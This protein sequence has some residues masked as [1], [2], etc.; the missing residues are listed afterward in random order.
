MKPLKIIDPLAQAVIALYFFIPFFSQGAFQGEYLEGALRG[1]YLTGLF[2]IGGWQVL[3]F[4]VHLIF[5]KSRLLNRYR[6]L[7]G[8]LLLFCVVLSFIPLL[9]WMVL[10][11]FSPFMALFYFTICTVEVSRIFT[12]R[13]PVFH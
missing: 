8:Y 13:K 6:K 7:Y 9:G 10:L 11:Y 1:E 12:K 2:F 5:F 4:V 3:S